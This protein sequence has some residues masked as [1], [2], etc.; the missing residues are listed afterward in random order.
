MSSEQRYIERWLMGG[1]LMLLMLLTACSSESAEEPLK[2]DEAPV[3][4]LSLVGPGSSVVTRG[5]MD[6]EATFEENVINTLDAWVFDSHDHSFISYLH[7]NNFSFESDNNRTISLKLSDSFT[8]YEGLKVNVYVVANVTADNCGLT[9]GANTTETQLNAACI[10]T[11]SFGVSSPVTSV[12]Y[13]GLPMSGILKDKPVDGQA[14]VFEVMQGKVK[15]VRAVSKMRFVFSQSISNPPEVSDLSISL[16]SGMLPNNEY[17]FLNDI[18]PTASVNIKAADD[19]NTDAVTLVSGISSAQISEY[20]DPASYE[21]KEEETAQEYETRINTGINAGHLTERR[22]YLRESDK[23]IFGKISYT[24]GSGENAVQKNVEFSMAE[25][26][27]FSRN[28]TW[29]VYGYFLG[30]G[31]LML[32]AVNV[33]DWANETENYKLHNW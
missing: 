2:P 8:K 19:Y 31:N 26:D 15:L 28:H 6:V 32:N 10:G 23:R 20:S 24:I 21:Y 3:L 14:P 27:N 33:K 7:L 1:M 18:Y 16:N 11:S 13:G 12:P 4:R 5:D 17:L 25:T 9:L 30:S 29:I 22:F